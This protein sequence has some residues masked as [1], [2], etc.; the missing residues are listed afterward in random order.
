MPNCRG[1]GIWLLVQYFCI[2]HI[3]ICLITL[4]TNWSYAVAH[5]CFFP[6]VHTSHLHATCRLLAEVNTLSSDESQLRWQPYF[7]SLVPLFLHCEEVG[8]R[9]SDCTSYTILVLPILYYTCTS[10]TSCFLIL[11]KTKHFCYFCR[12]GRCMCIVFQPQGLMAPLSLLRSECQ[13]CM[14]TAMI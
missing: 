6:H 3:Y 4:Y 7:H 11:Y 2:T 8:E 5:Y 10:C 13:V 14:W 12:K 1:F 9:C